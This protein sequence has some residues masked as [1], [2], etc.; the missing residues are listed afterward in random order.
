MNNLLAYL[1][2]GERARLFPVLADTSKEGRSLSIFLACLQ[3]VDEFGRA[4]LG[5]VEQRV[6][7]TTKIETFTE[8][9]L[10]EKGEK[11]LRPDGLIVLRSARSQWSALVEAKVGN[12]ELTS[13][14]ISGYLELAKLN[15]IDAVITISNQFAALP[16]HHPINV[17]TALLKKVALFHWPWM[18][19]LT[20]ASL[21]LGKSEVKDRDQ[22]V[23]LNEMQRFL[24]HP[25]AGL[26]GFDQMPQ[27]WSDTVATIAAGG[28]LTM[29]SANAK[30]VVGAW[31]QEIRDLSLILSRQIL[32]GVET[33]IARAHAGDPLA[34]QKQDVETLVRSARLEASFQV[35]NAA[36]PIEI[37]ADLAKRSVTFSMKLRAPTDR[38]STKAR[39]NWLLKQLGEADPEDLHIRLYWP[40]RTASSQMALR[41]LRENPDAAST[42]R[43]GQSVLSF[44]VLYVLNSGTRFAQ[45]RNFI[46]DLETALPRFYENVA[47]K[48]KPWQP[49]P[50]R[51]EE[52]KSTSASVSP[53]ALAEEAERAA[54][55]V[56]S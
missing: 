16:T 22:H 54:L 19:I 31:H 51:L 44:D 42:D 41:Q 35:P 27:A 12:S 43:D 4:M 11:S 21:L 25:S 9:V 36:A 1:K 28:K 32:A 50:P 34:R 47:E 55:A 37:C 26:K 2:R 30:E 53:Q 20:E 17:P 52:T 48:L 5:T 56:E 46:A 45:R 49:T 14:Q 10:A 18:S 33:K 8:V 24:T 29:S 3:I 40:G 23:I 13:E 38:K 39:V 15:K 6:G 7:A